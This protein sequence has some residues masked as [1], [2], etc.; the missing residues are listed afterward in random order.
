MEPTGHAQSV[1]VNSR[2]LLTL[3][4]IAPP[5]EG[6]ISVPSASG[7]DFQPSPVTQGTESL[8]GPLRSYGPFCL[9]WQDSGSEISVFSL[10]IAI[11]KLPSSAVFSCGKSLVVTNG[12]CK[13]SDISS[14]SSG[15][16]SVFSLKG[17]TQ[18][19]L[20]HFHLSCFFLCPTSVSGSGP[21]VG[22]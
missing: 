19:S 16:S 2:V 9:R 12:A 18:S 14:G 6:E 3:S 10:G 13:K 4:Q 20:F 17:S 8:T 15:N 7:G 22:D 11:F 5:R 1:G 21:Q